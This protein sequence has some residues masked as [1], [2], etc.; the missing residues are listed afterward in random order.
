MR[1]IKQ[2]PSIQVAIL[3]AVS[4][5]CATADANIKP[6]DSAFNALVDN[7]D[8]PG[9]VILVQHQG[10]LIHEGVYGLQD[11]ESSKPMQKDTIFRIASQ[12]K[13]VVSV[14]VMMLQE[15]G[16]LLIDEPVGNYIP[17]YLQTVVSVDPASND[18]VATIAANLSL[19][20][21]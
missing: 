6:L 2:S 18:G 1:R 16:Q 20:H 7:G 11:V 4:V 3:F 17:E 21:I 15:D 5:F 19:I 14:A 12:T 10:D 9:A 8:I 13:A